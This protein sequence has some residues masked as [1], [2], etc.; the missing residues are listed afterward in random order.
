MI[1]FFPLNLYLLFLTHTQL[2]LF[3]QLKWFYFFFYFSGLKSYAGNFLLR[4]DSLL[5]KMLFPTFLYCVPNSSCLFTLYERKTESLFISK[6]NDYQIIFYCFQKNDKML[7]VKCKTINANVRVGEQQCYQNLLLD[8]VSE[9]I[10]GHNVKN[11][12]LIWRYG[13]KCQ[14]FLNLPKICSLPH[15]GYNNKRH[16]VMYIFNTCF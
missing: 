11:I 15:K 16:L 2:G 10:L 1:T 6:Q 9:S 4:L 7:S 3:D 14:I 12:F 5:I 8:K 13:T